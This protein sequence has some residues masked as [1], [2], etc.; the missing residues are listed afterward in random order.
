MGH[1]P[2]V[3]VYRRSPNRETNRFRC[4]AAEAI[5]GVTVVLYTL[6]H[7]EL[8]GGE[9]VTGVVY[10]MDFQHCSAR[11]GALRSVNAIAVRALS[12]GRTAGICVDILDSSFWPEH[13]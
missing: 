6:R 4:V 8:T 9:C 11:I 10:E 5:G 3:A 13:S 7:K 1:R 2:T 12:R